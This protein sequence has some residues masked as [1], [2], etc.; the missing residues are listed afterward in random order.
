[1]NYFDLDGVVADWVAGFEAAFDI[2][3]NEFNELD[4]AER[5]E[6]KKLLSY[7]F[8][9]NLP[10]IAHGVAMFNDYV[11]E[12]GIENVA[13]LSAHGDY[14]VTE[15]IEAKIEWV[16]EHLSADVAVF[17]VPKLEDKAFFATEDDLLIDDRERAVDAFV[18]AGG[19]AILFV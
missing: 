15:V 1:M 3:I 10:V 11:A 9:R 18:A 13:I 14:N 5:H 8:F 12:H 6:Y 4:K 17:L 7:D 16:K 19:R 2:N